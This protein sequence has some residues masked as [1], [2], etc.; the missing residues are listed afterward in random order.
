[1]SSRVSEQLR[2]LTAFTSPTSYKSGLIDSI[3]NA[4]SAV[5]SQTKLFK[6]PQTPSTR[7]NSAAKPRRIQFRACSLDSSEVVYPDLSCILKR[8]LI[9][10]PQTKNRRKFSNN[11]IFKLRD[12][13]CKAL[14]S[15]M[16]ACCTI[17]PSKKFN[18]SIDKEKKALC[19]WSKKMEKVTENLMKLADFK[20]EYIESLYYYNKSSNEDILNDVLKLKKKKDQAMV[21]IKRKHKKRASSEFG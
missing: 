14:N 2:P 5:F 12:I 10:S 21:I 7:V 19:E 11:E 6:T 1:M 13:R 20:Q 8:D 17:K 18:K 9:K 15:L 16:G 4:E 3:Y